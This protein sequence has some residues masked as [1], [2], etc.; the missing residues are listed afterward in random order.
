MNRLAY[1]VDTERAPVVATPAADFVIQKLSASD[2]NNSA[3]TAFV[4]T[5]PSRNIIHTV[6]DGEVHEVHLRVG[7]ANSS[8]NPDTYIT[9]GETLDVLRVDPLTESVESDPREM[10]FLLVGPTE[11][12]IGATP[13]ATSI[14][15]FGYIK[16]WS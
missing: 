8:V 4:F 15:V 6:P 16:K 2:E 14:Q 10:V 11:V 12:R 3:R 1:I 13:N 7:N 9:V 5:H